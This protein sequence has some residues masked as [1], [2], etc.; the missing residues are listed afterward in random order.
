MLTR[1]RR[2]HRP[3]LPAAVL[4]ALAT[5]MVGA[6]GEPTN[7]APPAARA[8]LTVTGPGERPGTLD[9]APADPTRMRFLCAYDVRLKAGPTPLEVG[10]ARLTIQPR[11]GG[12]LPLASVDTFPAREVA[13]WLGDAMLRGGEVVEVRL[14]T[15]ITFV[16]TSDRYGATGA[17]RATWAFAY[18]EAGDSARYEVECTPTLRMLT[19]EF[20][21]VRRQRMIWGLPISVDSQPMTSRFDGRVELPDVVAGRYGVSVRDA[22]YAPIDTVVHALGWEPSVVRVARL[23]PELETMSLWPTGTEPPGSAIPEPGGAFRAYHPG[24][25]TELP[26]RLRLE[27]RDTTVVPV[28]SIDVEAVADESDATSRRYAFSADGR[29]M[30]HARV[31]LPWRDHPTV[32]VLCWRTPWHE[33]RCRDE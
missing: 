9:E 11:A 28:R 8:S 20:Q 14:E 7:P 33:W 30:T 16:P 23:A 26:D 13:G 6:C 21:D 5:L 24:G 1:A 25:V 10:G 29:G 18:G 3:R 31:V 17:H 19:I 27:L 12:D 32:A 22:R 15:W 2:S 4:L